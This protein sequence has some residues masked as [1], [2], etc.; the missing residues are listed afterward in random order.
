[1]TF[2]EW[3]DRFK[4]RDDLDLRIGLLTENELTRTLRML[5]AIQDKLGIANDAAE[6][7][8]FFGKTY[9]AHMKQSKRFVPFLFSQRSPVKVF[10]KSD[11]R[12]IIAVNHDALLLTSSPH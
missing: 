4:A 7:I 3:V 2:G 8:R 5:D 6:W 11:F 10:F 9:H 1:L 12:C